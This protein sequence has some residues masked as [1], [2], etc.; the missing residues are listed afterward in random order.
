MQIRYLR[1]IILCISICSALGESCRNAQAQA[2]WD[3]PEFVQATD[4]YRRG[5]CQTAWELMWP[6]AKAGQHEAKYFLWSTII[7]RFLRPG[8]AATS[9]A[10]LA[11]HMLTL[12]VHTA[13]GPHGQK[14]FQGDPNYR[15]AK[16]EIP[17]LLAQ[18][19]GSASEKSRVA[20]CYAQNSQFASC[21]AL[22]IRL[23]VI[24]RFDEYAASVE[25]EQRE[26]GISASCRPY[27]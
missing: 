10:R 19:S 2:K 21:L 22:A 14:P 25:A 4:A 5:D 9:P 20:Q 12:A 18:V 6:L 13:A 17:L 7:D 8:G 16:R 26:T 15:W 3:F 1:F 23:G 24:Q 27:P 11:W